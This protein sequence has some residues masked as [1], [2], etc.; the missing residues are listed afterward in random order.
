[1]RPARKTARVHTYG[2]LAGWLVLQPGLEAV[3]N[4]ARGFGGLAARLGTI[5]LVSLWV[6]ATVSGVVGRV[7]KK[8]E[9]EEAGNG[10]GIRT[11]AHPMDMDNVY[12]NRSTTAYVH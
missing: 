2:W 7:G 1:M 8:S 6:T 5:D 11:I 12:L 3:V 4:G 9:E 10:P